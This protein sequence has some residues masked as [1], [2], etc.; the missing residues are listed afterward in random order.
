MASPTG[1]DG[2]SSADRD[3]LRESFET[4]ETMPCEKLGERLAFNDGQVQLEC[5]GRSDPSDGVC[6]CRCATGWALDCRTGRPGTFPNGRRRTQ[7]APAPRK[8]PVRALLI[9]GVG[10]VGTTWQIYRGRTS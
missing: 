6:Q 10:F 9:Q 2:P 1:N 5:F 8:L 4:S 3:A 7:R